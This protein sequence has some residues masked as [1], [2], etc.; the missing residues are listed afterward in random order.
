MYLIIVK[1][2]EVLSRAA[3][4]V[5]VT[6]TLPLEQ[7][8]QFGIIVTVAGLF[9]FVLGWERYIDIQ[10]RMV[11]EPAET[12]DRA[13]GNALQ[14][15]LFNYA[16]ILP[17]YAAAMWWWAG[18]GLWGVGLAVIIV[19]SEQLANQVYQFALINPRFHTMLAVTA[20]RNV[21]LLLCGLVP[22]LFWPSQMTVHYVI[23]GW[24]AVS[25]VSLVVISWFWLRVRQPAPQA[26]AFTF[27]D[28]IFAQHRASLTHFL[29]G[30]I[31]ILV[32]QFDRLAV[33]ALLDLREVGVYF[34]HVL[35]VS[36]IYQ[37]FNITSYN[38]ILPR[39]FEMAKTADKGDQLARVRVEIAKV[40]A[41]V[42]LIAG[43]LWI[44]NLYGDHWFFA[45]YSLEW[46]LIL[47]LLAGAAVRVAADFNAMI[48]H[49]RMREQTVLMSQLVSFGAG[50]AL[51]VWM[52]WTFHTHGTAAAMAFTAALYF[53]LTARAVHLLPKGPR[54]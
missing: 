23:E 39:V 49:S 19:I 41:G 40:M 16:L 18:L 47:M 54:E 34:R 2:I 24:A 10:R 31:A 27:K 38:R 8:G 28:R 6:Y 45:R 26:Q 37:F 11:G 30:L 20:L 32:L 44:V 14:L 50:G 52:T 36:F 46:P 15:Y 17:V 1:L 9:A 7:A 48:L 3:F 22:I 4:V 43:G 29:I 5:G 53:A 25:F 35:M 12:F 13:I 21:A 33:G 42:T 51:M